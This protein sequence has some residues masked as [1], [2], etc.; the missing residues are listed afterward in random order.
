MRC[1]VSV[2]ESSTEH[3]VVVNKKLTMIS[4]GIVALGSTAALAQSG[5][6]G[7]SSAYSYDGLYLGASAGEVFY[8]EDGLGTISPT[9]AIF[10]VGEQFSPF[11]AIEGRIGTSVAGSTWGGYHV[12][13]Q[14]L[15]GGYVKGMLPFSPWF[16]AYAIA[17][18]GGAQ[19]HRNYPDYNSNDIGLSFGAGSEFNLGGGASLDV[20]YA[21][22]TNGSNSG[23]NYTADQLTFGVNWHI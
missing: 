22:L 5:Y 8:N 18:L 16:S 11:V 6:Y 14:A 3:E 9:V 1:I 21:R 12:D 4:A 19:F 15:Y 2:C 17:G 10:R 7:S 23:Y 20:E 13:V